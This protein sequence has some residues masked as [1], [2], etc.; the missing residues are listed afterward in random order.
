[1]AVLRRLPDI[2]KMVNDMEKEIKELKKG[3][4]A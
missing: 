1:M 4:Q 3:K 2:Y